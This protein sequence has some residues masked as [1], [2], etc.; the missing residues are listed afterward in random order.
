[1]KRVS[2]A[3]EPRRKRDKA[4]SRFVEDGTGVRNVVYSSARKKGK[5]DAGN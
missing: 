2:K 1:M 3:T 5:S 4:G